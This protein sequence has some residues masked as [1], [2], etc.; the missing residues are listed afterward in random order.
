MEL[1]AIIKASARAGFPLSNSRVR[2]LAWQYAEGTGQ[3]GFSKTSGRAGRD[4]LQSF[5]RRHKDIR[6]KKGKNLSINRAMCNNPVNINKWFD[7]YEATLDRLGI[8][9]CPDQIWNLDESGFQ[10]VPKEEKVIGVT[11][12]QAN[13]NVSGEKGETSTCVALI[14]GAG[15]VVP[16]MIIHKGAGRVNDTWLHHAPTNVLIK[17][18]PNGFIN[19]DTFLAFMER[20]FRWM[21][22]KRKLGRPNL[23]LLDGHK[24]HVY[25]T[26]F[27]KLCMD[28]DITVLCF[29]PHTSNTL[30]P[31]DKMP[32]SNT[33]RIWQ[34][35][36]LKWLFDNTGGRLPKY[37][38]FMVFWPAWMGGMSV[39]S[40]QGGFRVTGIYPCNRAAIPEKKLRTSIAYDRYRNPNEPESEEDN[41]PGY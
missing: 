27:L 6:V 37:E 9:D 13:Q 14:N 22:Y 16:P 30:Q 36:L 26:Q 35:E 8:R 3:T 25:N 12:E 11:G 23:L 19:K 32:F 2:K 29:P 24:S 41:D 28:N 10:D 38:F 20:A 39:A 7:L 34:K 40:I 1:V 17:A 21:G 4:W 18:T 5:L 15:V 31:L 33:K